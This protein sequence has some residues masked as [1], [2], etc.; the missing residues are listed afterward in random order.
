MEG[1]GLHDGRLVDCLQRPPA[2]AAPPVPAILSHDEK[3]KPFTEV[4]LTL[5]RTWMSAAEEDNVPTNIAFE[6]LEGVVSRGPGFGSRS[7]D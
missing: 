2:D 1:N 7:R 3:K 6:T 4:D 5:L